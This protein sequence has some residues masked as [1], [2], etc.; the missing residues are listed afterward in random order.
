[1]TQIQD[2]YLMIFGGYDMNDNVVSKQDLID[3][4]NNSYSSIENS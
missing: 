4:S 1:M 2:N 3:L